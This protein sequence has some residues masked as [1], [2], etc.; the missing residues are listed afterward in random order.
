MS[1]CR[2]GASHPPGL[3]FLPM[4]A[5]ILSPL[6]LP[7][8]RGFFRAGAAVHLIEPL[9][10]GSEGGQHA[11]YQAQHL[12]QKVGTCGVSNASLESIL[13]PRT[14]AAVRPRVR[15]PRPASS[16]PPRLPTHKL[17]AS[18]P[19]SAQQLPTQI[20]GLCWR[21]LDRPPNTEL[22]GQAPAPGP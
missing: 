1:H 12:R 15:G 9:H 19:G 18:G 10:G 3:P 5:L 16:L 22:Q 8:L 13:G 11:L 20:L 14:S 21:L 6:L 2:V 7:T 17:R 4:G